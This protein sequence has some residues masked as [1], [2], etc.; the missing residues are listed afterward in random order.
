MK[1][2]FFRGKLMEFKYTNEKLF[3]IENEVELGFI[4]YQ[5]NNN[6][7]IVVQTYVSELA[8]GKGVAK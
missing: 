3:A 7:I 6:E 8:R 5:L 1:K 2:L 4:W